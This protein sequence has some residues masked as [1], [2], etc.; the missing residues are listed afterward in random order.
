MDRNEL[1]KRISIDPAVMSG[2]PVIAGTR[3]PVSLIVNYIENGHPLAELL[4]DYPNLTEADVEAA[5]AY[6]R[7]PEFDVV[8]TY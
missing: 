6:A 3:V 4:D 8:R 2:V 5:L 7:I 1:Q